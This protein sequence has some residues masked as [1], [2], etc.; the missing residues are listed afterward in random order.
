MLDFGASRIGIPPAAVP[1]IPAAAE[2]V[3]FLE[4]SAWLEL[5]RDAAAAA[6][7]IEMK[8]EEGLL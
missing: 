2:P 1:T 5:S 4:K 6:K 8:V 7:K 3:R